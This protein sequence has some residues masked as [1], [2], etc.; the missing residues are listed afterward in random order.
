MKRV[1][2][3]SFRDHGLGICLAISLAGGAASS[4]AE[5][6]SWNPSQR[7]A[8]QDYLQIIHT[9][10][11]NNIAMLWWIAPPMMEGPNV[12]SVRDLLDR[13]VVVA[14]VNANI[15]P[16]GTWSFPTA[17]A[18]QVADGAGRQLWP[19]A[20]DNLPPVVQGMI[21]AIRGI[22]RQG[23]GAMGEGM[24]FYVFE[25]RNTRACAQGGLSVAYLAE[26]YT[27]ETPVPGC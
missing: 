18:P 27:W 10:S 7:D 26:T 12:E 1:S 16:D 25:S 2:L 15:S 9:R 14:V 8:A 23:I 6:R 11:Q 3:Q 21:V 19:L 5:A 4:I 13:Y 24:Q 22:V 20:G 17:E